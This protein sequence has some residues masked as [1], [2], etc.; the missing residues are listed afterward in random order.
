VKSNQGRPAPARTRSVGVAGVGFAAGLLYVV[1][2]SAAFV[3][4]AVLGWIAWRAFNESDESIGSRIARVVI[5]AVAAATPVLAVAALNRQ[6]GGSANILTAT[7]GGHWEWLYLL[8][9][10]TFPALTAADLDSLLTYV[11]MHPVHGLTRNALWLTIA[12]L[13]GGIL[14]A[15][16]A[17]RATQRGAAPALARMLFIVGSAALLV[18]WTLTTAVSIEPRH[19]ISAGMAM[20][21]L[22]IAEGLSWRASGARI[23]RVMLAAAAVVFVAA[24]LGYGVVSVFAKA[25]RYPADYRPSASGVFT[26]L[27]ADHDAASVVRALSA[28]FDPAHDV[29]Y[30]TDPVSTL[31]LPGRAIV[32]HA[33]FLPLAEL[34]GEQFVASCRMRVHALLPPRFEANGKGAAIRASFPQAARWVA[35]AIPDAEVVS[36]TADLESRGER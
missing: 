33:D 8:D 18:V 35:T 27:L 1:K 11:L 5:A 22:A 16:L 3:T 30:L 2:Y 34:R 31:D 13:P 7:G 28:G 24:P 21:P 32:R 23:V 14:L 29:W 19:V 20:L 10:V 9:A 36:W 15:V 17:L 12:G 26:P 6:G 25:A 4:A